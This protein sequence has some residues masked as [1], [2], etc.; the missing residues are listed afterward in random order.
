MKRIRI[1]SMLSL[2]LV[3]ILC[4]ALTACGGTS[5]MGSDS[6]T[7]AISQTDSGQSDDS[8]KDQDTDTSTPEMPGSGASSVFNIS[9]V[10]DVPLITLSN[11]VQVPQLG[12]GTQI[13]RLE[14]DRSES[15]RKLLNDT[16]HDVV[17]AALQSGYRHPV[18]H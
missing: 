18:Y 2:A 4:I 13:Q 12:L 1:S 7:S 10:A 11:G 8:Q 16:S 17:V 9:S 6:N 15:G 3:V 5:D 14:Q